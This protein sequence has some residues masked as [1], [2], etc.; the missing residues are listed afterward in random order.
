[1]YE[2]Y[3]QDPLTPEDLRLLVELGKPMF[4]ESK[5]IESYSSENPVHGGRP[6]DGSSKIRMGLEEMERQVRQAPFGPP[7]PPPIYYQPAPVA[8]TY[9][10]PVM[11]APVAVSDPGQMEF[12]FKVDE[13]K[14]TNDLLDMISAKLTK[15][16]RVLEKKQHNDAAPTK[17]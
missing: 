9:P 14:K 10:Q 12:N 2:N 17:P 16:L 11:V 3:Q 13:Q 5:M 6:D 15:I 7:P 4:M 8:P 1:M